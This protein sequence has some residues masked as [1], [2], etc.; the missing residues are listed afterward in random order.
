MPHVSQKKLSDQK[1]KEIYFDFLHIF[2][3]KGTGHSRKK[4]LGELLTPTEKVMLAKRL[5]IVVLLHKGVST[6]QIENALKV[7]PSTTARIRLQVEVGFY[8]EISKYVS[9]KGSGKDFLDIL[10][11]VIYAGMPPRVGGNRWKWLDKIFP[12]GRR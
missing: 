10:E 9:K 11:K 4:M 3:D 2:T 12:P 8:N 1:N 7:S 6:Y 5:A